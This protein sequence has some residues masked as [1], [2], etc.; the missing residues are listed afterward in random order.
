MPG[1]KPA[2]DFA[3]IIGHDFREPDLLETAL[4]HASHPGSDKSYQRLEFLGDRVLGLIVVDLLLRLFPGEDEGHLARRLSAIVDRNS[5]AA[6][7]SKL[8]LADF[9]RAE[10][11]AGQNN[12]LNS[13][14]V[15]ADVMEA[16]IAA[17]YRDGGLEVAR[18]FVEP[19]WEPLA[20]NEPAPPT[21]AKTALQEY[22]QGQGKALPEYTVIAQTGP[23]HAPL[24]VVEVEIEGYAPGEGQGASKRAA[25]QAAAADLL[26]KLE[27]P[28]G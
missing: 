25:E 12:P 20:L 10:E 24:F 16:V 23:D 6:V 14:A 17:L 11:S 18:K 7:G 9:I 19:L 5:L 4:T 13:P 27:T 8:E 2:S 26:S 3:E 1:P 22:V 28:N 15:L 21:D